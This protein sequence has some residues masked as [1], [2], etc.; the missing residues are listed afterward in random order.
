MI[1]MT[2]AARHYLAICLDR[3]KQ[4]D[5][6][7]AQFNILVDLIEFKSYAR[8]NELTRSQ[9]LKLIEEEKDKVKLLD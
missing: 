2:E 6:S 7:D 9:I 1:M 5:I 3:D 8:L 4:L